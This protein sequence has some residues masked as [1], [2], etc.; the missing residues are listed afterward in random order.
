[1]PHY[2]FTLRYLLFFSK[3]WWRYRLSPE[4]PY[5]CRWFD[6]RNSGSIG[7][8]WWPW[9]LYQHQ[10]HDP[11]FRILCAQESLNWINQQGVIHKWHHLNFLP[12]PLLQSSYSEIKNSES[13]FDLLPPITS[14][15]PSFMDEPLA[16]Q[17]FGA[18]NRPSNFIFWICWNIHDDN[19]ESS[20]SDVWSF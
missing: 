10:V 9:C 7:K 12:P 6:P 20:H 17:R 18:W 3:C 16:T 15:V 4:V 19:F 8:T 13:L 14:W 11:H 1:M 2:L 5:Q